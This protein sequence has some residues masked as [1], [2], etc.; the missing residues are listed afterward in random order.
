MARL[1]KSAEAVAAGARDPLVYSVRP[2]GSAAPELA[3]VTLQASPL[4]IRV[5]YRNVEGG[6]TSA[7]RPT[8]F[9][10]RRP[11]GYHDDKIYKVLL[12]GD[13]A[14]LLLSDDATLDQCGLY[15]GYG[16][17][18][19]CNIVDAADQ[20]IPGFGPLPVKGSS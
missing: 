3:D 13:T 10:L 1:D 17:N 7:G 5:R 2:L 14:V 15:Y 6:L 8:G 4:A 9:S 19:Y 20:A 16:Y 11:D 12:E 18:P